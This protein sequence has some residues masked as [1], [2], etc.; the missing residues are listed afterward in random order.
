ASLLTGTQMSTYDETKYLL[1]K[2]K[3]LQEGMPLHILASIVAGLVTTT[4][5]APADIIK[6]RLLGQPGTTT[7]SGQQVPTTFIKT[8][9]TIIKTEGPKALFRG[10]LPSYCRL[11]PHFITSLPLFERLR[12]LMGLDAV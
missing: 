2:H 5:T 11:A 7:A 6:T 4:V 9:T 12:Y 1:K 8:L 10:W 3:I